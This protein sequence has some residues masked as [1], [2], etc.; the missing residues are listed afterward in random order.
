MPEKT[1]KAEKSTQRVTKTTTVGE[2]GAHGPLG[3]QRNSLECRGEGGAVARD[4]EPCKKQKKE[5][6]A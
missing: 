3:G 6:N 5:K 4:V 2:K 1:S